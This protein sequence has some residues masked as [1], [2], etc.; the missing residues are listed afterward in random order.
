MSD[1]LQRPRQTEFV[2]TPLKRTLRRFGRGIIDVLLPPRCLSCGTG[3]AGEG[4]LCA[5]CWTQIEFIDG[6][7]CDICGLPFEFDE[8]AGVLCGACVQ[9]RPAYQRHRSVMRY[10]E[11]SRSLILGFKHGDRTDGAPTYGA[12]LKRAGLAQI[13]EGTI[14]V[15]VPLHRKRLFTRRYNQSALLAQELSKSLAALTNTIFAPGLLRRTRP[16]ASQGN[17]S[18]SAR[19]R[20]VAGA[21][22]VHPTHTA[23]VHKAHILLIDDVMTTGATIEAC[24]KTLMR[25]GAA[26]VDVLTLARVVRPVTN[27]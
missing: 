15:P 20:N 17:L 14:I 4:A 22:V 7:V 11:A 12:W 24:A 23:H 3:L 1:I 27:V 2:P 9:K 25:A 19:F 21:F 18:R 8:G 13:R 5:P 10:T 6:P 16:T 26:S